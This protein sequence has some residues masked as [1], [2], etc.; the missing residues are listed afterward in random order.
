MI[1]LKVSGLPKAELTPQQVGEAAL[2]VD[3]TVVGV[4]GPR[5]EKGDDGKSAYEIA[6]DNGFSGTE[7]EW[8]LS[9]KGQK[10]ETGAT[11][12]QGPQGETGATG[13][14]GATGPQG[15]R[16]PQ[17]P[18]GETGATGATGAAGASAY[19]IAVANGFQGTEEE[20]LESLHGDDAPDRDFVVTYTLGQSDSCDKT[21]AEI[22]AA[23]LAG[24]NIIAKIGGAA[25][26]QTANVYVDLG[27]NNL[28]AV[29]TLSNGSVYRIVHTSANSVT[30]ELQEIT[31]DNQI[32]GASTNPV[33]NAAIAAAL[34]EKYTMPGNGIPASDL[35]ETYLTQHQDI[36]GKLDTTGDAYRTS[37]IPMG[38]LDATSTATVMT[39][40]VPGI[41]ELRDGV[42]VWLKNGVV[43]S[44]SGFTLN[45]NGLGAKPVYSSMEAA[46]AETTLFNVAYTM[47]FVYDSTRVSGGCWVLYRGYN[48]D[49]NTLAYQI[50]DYQAA[51]TMKSALY[52]YMFVFTAKDGTLVPSC[53]TSNSTSTSKTLT[54]ESFDPFGPIYYYTTTTTVNA[55]A[56]P[57]A[58]YM[59]TK[60]Y[61]CNMR[62][63]F[64]V[65]SSQLTAKAPVYIKCS[66]QADGMVKLSGA[67]CIVQT[68]PST[69]DGYVYILLG[70][71][72]SAYQVDMDIKHPAYC[73]RN[74]GIQQWTGVQAELDGKYELPSGGI[75]VTDLASGVIPPFVLLTMDL[76]GY[77]YK[78]SDT[79]TG[80]EINTLAAQVKAVF[81]WDEDNAR[82]YSYVENAN[83][84]V[85]FSSMDNGTEGVITVPSASYTG[86]YTEKHFIQAPSGATDGQFLVYDGTAGAW[87]AQT[88]PSASGVSF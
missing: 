5:G 82:L 87:G 83:G 56:S 88:V 11:G 27:N 42:C 49:T 75:P 84:G 45:I 18:Q 47:L 59:Y 79:I 57:S 9:L 15:P 39:A 36:S 80:A 40:T 28:V 3:G 29:L 38:Q 85:R 71:A 25:Y 78:G 76:D 41:T 21:Y 44:A 69:E 1:E 63:G 77:V 66:P 73:Y 7:A 52:R 67:S 62:Y 23:W 13:A 37:S 74:S 31:V 46:S 48:S 43:T 16:G 86:A 64:N 34:G 53:G 10:G 55:G 8:L 72:Y 17:G 50:R 19:Q 54:A 68:L 20:W 33:T 4:P 58:S 60:Y 81:L 51:K 65:G 30:S 35:E 24:K 70:Y 14:T 2:Q 12:P 61:A 22:V 6:V 32:N 26:G